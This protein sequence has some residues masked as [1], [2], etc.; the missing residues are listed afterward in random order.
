VNQCRMFMSPIKLIHSCGRSPFARLC[1][2]FLHAP[3]KTI[4]CA[5]NSIACESAC[6]RVFD[7]RLLRVANPKTAGG[8]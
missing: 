6:S 2:C 1:D 3:V 7:D 8:G 5:F 4:R